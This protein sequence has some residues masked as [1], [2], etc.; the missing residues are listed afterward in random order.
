MTCNRTDLEKEIKELEERVYEVVSLEECQRLT[1][2]SPIGVRWVDMRKG[3]GTYRSRLVAKDFRPKSKK[4]DVEGLYASMPPLELV[5]LLIARAARV[6]EWT[7]LI[8]IKKAHLYASSVSSAWTCRRKRLN[9]ASVHACCTPCTGCGWPPGTGRR[10]TAV[11]WRGTASWWARP[12]SAASTTRA[13]AS[14]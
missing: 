12:T 4:G 10:S 1:G 14:G 11:R 3:D 8:D 6:G 5:K 9:R 13:E 2:K 7:M